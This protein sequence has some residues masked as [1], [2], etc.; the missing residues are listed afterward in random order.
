M[1]PPTPLEP[2][3]GWQRLVAW[4]RL[5]FAAIVALIW[6][7][8]LS[9]D[10]ATGVASWLLRAALVVFGAQLAYGVAEQWPT[11][12]PRW[13]ARWVLQL[14]AVVV[15]VPVMAFLGYT[16]TSPWP[17][18]KEVLRLQG[19]GIVSF[20]GI[21]I[22]PWMALAAMVRA[23]DALARTQ[24][25]AFDLA[26]SELE[27]QALDARLRLLQAQVEPHFLFN[28]LANVRALVGSGSPKAAPVL[29]SLIAYLRAAVPRLHEKATTLGQEL[30]L[31]RAY[32]ELMHLRMPDR[33]Q[34]TVQADP[35]LLAQPC[36][37]MTVLTLVEN[38][39]RHGIDP[40][41][42]GGRIDVLAQ[43]AQG[44][45]LLRV[46]DSGIGLG[47]S[48]GST[49][50]G[51]ANLRERLQL[52]FAGQAQLRLSGALPRGVVAEVDWPLHTVAQTAPA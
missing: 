49:G 44:R 14:L 42:D 22:G 32:L 3:R 41:E 19:F 4:P 30:D 51:L 7:L 15:T 18:W 52:A 29:D 45:C 50:T 23:R 43:Q 36:P 10:S 1:P 27:R 11:R 12:L 17:F 37:P 47:A 25:L 9:I 13:L 21:L 34:F 26:R 28:T 16:L 24:Q 38:A 46:S 33:L 39:V 6:G 35:A 31:V 5:R 40:A 48:N 8:L 20:V 2:V